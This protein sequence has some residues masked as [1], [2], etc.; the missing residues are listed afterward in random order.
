MVE[1]VE[2][3]FRST[4]YKV[5]RVVLAR[6]ASEEYFRRFWWIVL[7]APVAGAFLLATGV[8]SLQAIGM[9]G[10]LWPTSIPT[11]AFFITS[12]SGKLL[13][14]GV[15]AIVEADAIYFTTGEH[16][17]KLHISSVR[18]MKRRHGF[19]VITLRKFEF[20]PIPVS[21][22]DKPEEFESFV[23]TELSKFLSE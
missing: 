20:V 19:F 8:Q 23:S 21:A 16:G 14:Q 9:L 1:N 13:E 15:A 18:S 6:L 22:I 4:V 3:L 5:N 10:I 2:P 12:K 17:F 11:R 7:P